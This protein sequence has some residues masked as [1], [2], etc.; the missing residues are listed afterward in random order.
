MH[1]RD[2]RNYAALLLHC[3]CC[4]ETLE[5]ALSLQGQSGKA[6]LGTPK[7]GLWAAMKPSGLKKCLA[8]HGDALL[9]E[10]SCR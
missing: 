6:L 8:K 2:Q 3:P 7:G 9:S 1:G 10:A 4:L 5:T